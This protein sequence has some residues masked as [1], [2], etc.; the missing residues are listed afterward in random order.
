MK[1]ITAMEKEKNANKIEE[2]I[3]MELDECASIATPGR[4]RNDV[5]ILQLIAPLFLSGVTVA[6]SCGVLFR[7]LSN[8]MGLGI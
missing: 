7:V 6:V 1:G 2:Q 3:I 5:P 4:N 8:I